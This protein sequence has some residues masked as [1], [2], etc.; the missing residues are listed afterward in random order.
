MLLGVVEDHQVA[1]A[2][3]LADVVASEETGEVVVV[4]AARGVASPAGVLLVV[5]V[6]QEDVEDTDRIG[7]MYYCI[8][9]VVLDM[10]VIPFPANFPN[11]TANI[12]HQIMTHTDSTR[13][14]QD[15]PHYQSI[16][17]P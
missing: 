2:V 11:V 15:P 1:D 3:R 13:S 14:F 16:R 12:R 8:W 7:I 6:R 9:L 17:E 5:A 4:S 10:R